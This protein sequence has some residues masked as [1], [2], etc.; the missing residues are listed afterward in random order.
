MNCGITTPPTNDATY[1]L[2]HFFQ[3]PH[4]PPGGLPVPGRLPQTARAVSALPSS[5]RSAAAAAT[6]YSFHPQPVS[7]SVS[8]GHSIPKP[9]G[10]ARSNMR[11]VWPHA[12]HFISRYIGPSTIIQGR[13]VRDATSLWP[14]TGQ[15]SADEHIRPSSA[16]ASFPK[17]FVFTYSPEECFF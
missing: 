12:P 6:A 11:H 13:R 16:R 8:M 14:Q 9:H 3:E 10:P 17:I 1:A 2:P 15:Q 4:L 5:A 7:I